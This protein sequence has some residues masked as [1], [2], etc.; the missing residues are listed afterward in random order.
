MD[1]RDEMRTFGQLLPEGSCFNKA[2]MT[3]FVPL[4]D[5]EE[6][7]ELHEFHCGY[8]VC[9]TCG[10]RGTHVNPSIDA[11]G[12]STDEWANDWSHQ[13][14]ENYFSGFYDVACYECGGNKVIPQIIIEQADK[15]SLQLLLDW[16]DSEIEY[17]KEIA[18][19]RKMGW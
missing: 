7:D 15:K 6:V 19:E 5:E 10:G 3:L 11:H 12:I 14:R 18:W 13:D 1:R 4:T 2:T 16:Q 9:H 8:E 17:R